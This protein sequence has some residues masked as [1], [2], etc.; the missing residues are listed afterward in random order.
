MV[1]WIRYILSIRET[2]FS[3]I[4]LE[5]GYDEGWTSE[6]TEQTTRK[7]SY[8]T[9]QGGILP[10]PMS[11]KERTAKVRNKHFIKKTIH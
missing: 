3:L 2:I 9:V 8:S 6:E 1:S 7:T 5:S 4:D 10:S 11:R